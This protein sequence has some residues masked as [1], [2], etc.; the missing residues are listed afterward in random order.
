[1]NRISRSFGNDDFW[2]N[3][4]YRM[5]CFLICLSILIPCLGQEME[6]DAFRANT[7]DLSASTH[8]RVDNNGEACGLVKVELPLEGVTFEGNIIDD[9][10]YN[11]GEYWVYLTSG[12]KN[13]RIKHPQKKPLSVNFDDFGIKLEGSQTYLL[14]I[15]TEAGKESVTFR[16]TPKNAILTVDQREYS[17]ENGTA[18]IPL[19]PEEHNYTIVAPGYKTQGNKFMV[20]SGQTNKFIIEL[21]PTDGNSSSSHSAMQTAPNSSTAV[22]NISSGSTPTTGIDNHVLQK[23]I[24][25]M[26]FVEGGSF[27][28]GSDDSDAYDDE[29]PVHR[30]NV[31]SFH[32]GKYEVTQKEWEAVMGNNPSNFKGGDLPV[33]NVSWDDC[34]EFIWRLNSMTGKNFRL[35]TEA[36]WEYAARGGINNHNCKFSGSNNIENVA[37][38]D[39]NSGNTTHP[40]GT[41]LANELGLHDMSGNVWEWTSDN[42]C[43]NYN[44]PR[45]S[46]F[47]VSRGGGWSRNARDCRSS[48]RDNYGLS[49]RVSYLGLRLAF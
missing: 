14:S 20:Y 30:E 3:A 6:V 47:F 31:G 11:S 39:G 38:Y 13:L 34:Q 10:K 21:D 4:G 2:G 36:E 1:M 41:K 25:N 26:V 8:K 29:K 35:P 42:W 15:K 49:C 43:D 24:D 22:N 17:T 7:M 32:I 48:S 45:N 33:E 9:V 5:L 12:S 27:M 40:V 19:T 46:S 44:Q 23:L 16:I 18:V 37:W 28:M